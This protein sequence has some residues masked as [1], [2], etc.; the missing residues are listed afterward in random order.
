MDI[1]ASLFFLVAAFIGSVLLT[2][3]LKMGHAPKKTAHIHG[4]LV[5]TGL[6]LL[7][8]YAFVTENKN[9]QIDTIL[10]FLL[11]ASLGLYLYSRDKKQQKPNKWAAFLHAALGTG[12]LIWILIYVLNILK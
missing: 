5:V 8:I 2:H 4:A 1:I 7:I 12:G 3:L 11:A 6:V 9:K 10:I